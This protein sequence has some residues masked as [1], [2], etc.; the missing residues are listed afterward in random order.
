MRLALDITT[1]TLVAGALVVFWASGVLVPQLH[2]VLW[3]SSV[4]LATECGVRMLRARGRAER[5]EAAGNRLHWLYPACFSA[6]LAAGSFLYTVEAQVGA[7]LYLQVLGLLLVSA[8]S[9]PAF[10]SVHRWASSWPGRAF[11]V[12]GTALLAHDLGR[13]AIGA[14]RFGGRVGVA[15]HSPFPRAVVVQGGSS[16][17]TNHH[18]LSGEQRHALDLLPLS[19]NAEA[20]TLLPCE[21]Q[22]V[23]S[24]IDGLVARVVDTGKGRRR[25]ELERLAGTFVVLSHAETTE[26][27]GP[28]G[29]ILLAHLEPGSLVA[30][31]GDEVRVGQPLGMCGQSG[32]ASQRHLH[33]Q[34]QNADK[35]ARGVET[36]PLIFDDAAGATMRNDIVGW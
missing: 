28:C 12:M 29:W 2:V 19:T 17:L 5:S 25:T 10:A 20:P 26:E 34:A 4:V 33:L 22:L 8:A 36:C 32:S 21:G 35:L 11:F 7:E 27:R 30:V 13:E 31:P 16:P 6:S 24:P 15:V 9:L 23:H 1:V 18:F 14:L 3:I